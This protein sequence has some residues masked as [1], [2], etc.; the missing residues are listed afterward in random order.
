MGTPASWSPGSYPVPYALDP[1]V[2]LSSDG[3][4]S[5]LR[6]IARVQQIVGKEF[7]AVTSTGVTATRQLEAA[8]EGDGAPTLTQP[9]I[10]T[11]RVSVFV[12]FSM[13]VEA[14]WNQ[15]LAELSFMIADAKD[16]EEATSFLSGNG[17]APQPAG[18]L[19]TAVASLSTAV[20][21]TSIST[22]VVYLAD[23]SKLEAAVPPRFRSQSQVMMSTGMAQFLKRCQ[24][25]VGQAALT[26]PLDGR[27]DLM[28]RGAWV[29]TGM[30]DTVTFFDS[31]SAVEV[32]TGTATSGK[33]IM[34]Q[35]DFKQFA[36]I[37]RIGL[38][39][40]LVPVVFGTANNYP[41]GQ[42]G[43][44]AMWRSGSG[45]LAENA[46]RYLKVR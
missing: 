38:S 13:E 8:E 26:G 24:S 27:M 11:S 36:I 16:V 28:G 6:K 12:P 45:V 14:D 25:V 3:A 15:L 46:F 1:T 37:D 7:L 41:T 34:V 22:A 5:P 33:K 21:V 32:N 9:A 44:F 2:T 42:R 43:V 10:P 31:A 18:L 20:A 39:I 40:E 19:G 29:H 17:N 30:D 4:T 35:G 23:V